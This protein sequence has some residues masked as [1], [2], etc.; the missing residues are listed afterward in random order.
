MKIVAINGS[1]R[2]K[3]GNTNVMV[4]AFLK[5]AEMA[6]AEIANIFLME[7]DIKYCLACKTCWFN[8]PGKCIIKDDMAEI[9]SV[10]EDADIR[11]LATPLYCDNISGML[12][13]FINRLIITASPYWDKDKDGEC[14]HV[15]RHTSPKLIMIANCG[16]PERTHFQI[17]SKWIQRVA[18]NMNTEVIGEIYASQGA[19]LSSNLEEIRPIIFNYIKVLEV[20]GEEIATD[21]KL[22]QKTNRLLEQKFIS[23]EIYIQEVKRYADYMLKNRIK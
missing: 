10:I 20:A 23:D 9:M 13:V 17:I 4:S 2:G 14:R 7:K 12:N 6:G 11:I 16:Y 19:L 1:H 3:N 5:G 18:R 22:S 21:M 15:T 8:N